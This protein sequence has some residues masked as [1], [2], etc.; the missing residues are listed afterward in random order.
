MTLYFFCRTVIFFALGHSY[1]F[2]RFA[3]LRKNKFLLRI[4]LPW[5]LCMGLFPLIFLW[6]P[7]DSVAQNLLRFAGGIWQPFAYFCL[8]AFLFLDILR[9]GAWLGRR[10][11]PKRFRRQSGGPDEAQAAQEPENHCGRAGWNPA[12]SR[13]VQV[14]LVLGALFFAYGLH[15]AGDLHVTRLELPT[16]KLPPGV[17]RL[18]L[19][20]ASDLHISPHFGGQELGRVVDLI[21]A[22]KPDC[23]LL[24]GDILDDAM[25]GTPN[26]FQE[27]S[28]LRAPLGTFAVLGNHDA[29]GDASRP[30]KAL[31]QAGIPVLAAQRADAGPI[32]IIGVDDPEVSAQ[33]KGRTHD[34]L[35]LLRQADPSRFT[36]LLDHRPKVRPKSVGLFDLQ[37][38][39]HSHGGQICLLT[40]MMRRKYHAPNGLSPCGAKAGKSMLFIT[41]GVGFSK[42]P[43]RLFVPPEVVIIDLVRRS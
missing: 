21:L 40:P 28:R 43:I 20:F 37:L 31:R 11:F 27:L 24:G 32:S 10:I 22:Q 14:L 16:D 3:F 36:I 41:T 29:F 4:S 34:P 13:P 25:Q 33:K 8:L 18:R 38:S 12:R 35:P 2:W 26:D 42:L 7:P 5:F 1:L 17:N 23:I 19:A 9:I 30:A 6:L 39:G 15:E